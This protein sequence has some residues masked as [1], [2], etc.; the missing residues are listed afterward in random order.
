MSN[1]TM[2]KA[3][4]E[5]AFLLGEAALRGKNA[6]ERYPEQ[7]FFGYLCSYYP[8]ELILAAGLE[9]L[10]LLPG[11]G[12]ATPAELP[13]Y[14]CSL[15]RGTLAEAKKGKNGLVGVGMA[16]TCDTMQCLDGIWADRF[17]RENVLPIVPPVLLNAPGGL[18]YYQREMEALS[19]KLV[20]LSEVQKSGQD[21]SY[22][23]SNNHGVE[24]EDA[25]N[26]GNRF[27]SEGDGEGDGERQREQALERAWQVCTRARQL[28]AELDELRP[29]LPS[30]LVSALLLAGQLLPKKRFIAALETVLPLLRTKAGE[31]QGRYR[32]LVSGAVLETDSLFQMIEDLNGRVVADDTCTGYRHY[33]QKTGGGADDKIREDEELK[34]SRNSQESILAQIVQRY[35]NM[36]P[37]PCRSQG[38]GKRLDYLEALALQRG[39]QAAILVIRKYCEPHAWDAVPVKERLEA[40]G[41]RTLVLE[42]EASEVGGQERTRLQAFLESLGN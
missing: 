20:R 37:C 17:G 13:S 9:P 40:R 42:L 5:L 22:E 8:E 29:R 21:R 38:L 23:P 7:R 35:V 11:S 2:L 27:E 28:A 3:E 4:E 31:A 16:H 14:C 6:A 36:P 10:R 32:V 18:R 26:E 39:A 1:R 12:P 25:K 41:I 19:A 15:A 34:D 30:P 24:Q 33:A